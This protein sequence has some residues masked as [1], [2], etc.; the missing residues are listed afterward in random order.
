MPRVL[1]SN[2]TARLRYKTTD[3][4]ALF[5]EFACQRQDQAKSLSSQPAASHEIIPLFACHRKSR[6]A[7]TW[8]FL[9]QG[10]AERIEYNPILHIP[11]SIVAADGQDRQRACPLGGPAP[12]RTCLERI[13]CR[14]VPRGKPSPILA[15]QGRQRGW[16][17]AVK[18]PELARAAD[19]VA[20]DESGESQRFSPPGPSY[21]S[22][23]E[24]GGYRKPATL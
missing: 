16:K 6:L 7:S 8:L 15:E 9:E 12:S 10:H 1:A 11:T 4:I 17:N 22:R 24:P 23:N 3:K 2:R 18:S 14:T 5:G 20:P 19:R 21:R 13:R